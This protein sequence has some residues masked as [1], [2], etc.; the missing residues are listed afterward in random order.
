LPWA[1]STNA[2]AN[3]HGCTPEHQPGTP[4]FLSKL[5]NLILQQKG[6]AMTLLRQF[7]I[8]AV[9]LLGLHSAQATLVDRGGGLLYDTVL[10]VTWLQDA[11]YART[12]NYAGA[13]VFGAMNWGTAVQWADELNYVDTVRGTVWSDWRLPQVRPINGVSY[14]IPADSSDL[15][16]GRGDTDFGFNIISPTSELSYMYYVNLGLRGAVGTDGIRRTDYG[17]FENGFQT[18]CKDFD[19]V[20]NICTGWYWSGSVFES[21][22]RFAFR[23]DSGDQISLGIDNTLLGWAVRDGDVLAVTPPPPPN[24][25]PEPTGV[26]LVGAAL[27][28][29]TAARRRFFR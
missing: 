14:T 12:T 16:R 20:K 22:L 7:T 10:N 2:S 18:G 4:G 27:L 8:S 24:G 9:A 5:I 23:T 28:G 1:R 3:Q 25:A 21:Y 19:L 17:I 13:N 26:W 29:M 15:A 11:N 6:H